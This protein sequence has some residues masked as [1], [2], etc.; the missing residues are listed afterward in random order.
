MMWTAD[1]ENPAYRQCR[2]YW[3]DP[4]AAPAGARD[5]VIGI[6]NL[7]D[8]YDVSLKQAR[9]AQSLLAYPGFTDVRASLEDRAAINAAFATHQPHRVVNLA[10]QAGVRYSIQNPHAYVDSNLVGFVNVL[11]ACRHQGVEHLVYAS[12]SRCMAPTRACRSR[13]MT[14]SIIR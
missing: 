6:D 10:A 9:L 3:F 11:E 1:C 7:N 2:L 13:C 12:T 5:T 14:T 8:Y 4:C